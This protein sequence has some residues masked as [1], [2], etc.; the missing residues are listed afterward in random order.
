M[1]NDSF[2]IF[3]KVT[4]EISKQCHVVLDEEEA[5]KEVG[6]SHFHLNPECTLGK[7]VDP[8]IPDDQA[9]QWVGVRFEMIEFQVN[10]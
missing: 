2:K 7:G 6:K 4:N 3:L 8:W 1:R 9:H 5:E 10:S